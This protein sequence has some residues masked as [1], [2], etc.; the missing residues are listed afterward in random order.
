MAI[1]K[2][3]MRDWFVEGRGNVSGQLAK[4]NEQILHEESE[5][6]ELYGEGVGQDGPTANDHGAKP[7]YATGDSP[8]H[9]G[10]GTGRGH[11]VS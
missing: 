1:E 7:I 9:E 10:R 3:M 5:D 2:K 6:V 8:N 4:S 11:G